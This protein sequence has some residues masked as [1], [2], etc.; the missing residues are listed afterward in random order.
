MFV[1]Q[2]RVTIKSTYLNVNLVRKIVSANFYAFIIFK[3]ELNVEYA[4]LFSAALF[5]ALE[6]KFCIVG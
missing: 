1:T 4:L 6:P 2:N 3:E 5:F